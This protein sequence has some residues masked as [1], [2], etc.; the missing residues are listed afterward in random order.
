MDPE[1]DC[2]ES[3]RFTIPHTTIGK[4][5]LRCKV[6]NRSTDDSKDDATPRSNETRCWCCSDKTRDG[7]RTPADHGPFAGQ[8]PIEDHPGHCGEHCGQIRV[9]TGHDCAKIGAKSRTAVEPQ[10]AEPQQHSSERDE[11][12][13]M[14]PEIQ[15]HPLLSSAKNPRVCQRRHARSNLDRSTSRIVKPAPF[16][17]PAIDIPCPTCHRAVYNCGPKEGEDH[18]GNEAAALGNCTDNDGGCN[19]AELHL[20]CISDCT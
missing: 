20:E 3:A 18:H 17:E 10:P 11:R 19:G 8:S 13:V 12:D 15:H 6:A 4:L 1:F 5:T 14:R 2:E 9:P 16:V 7:T